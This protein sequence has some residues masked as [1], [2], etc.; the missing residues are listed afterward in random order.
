MIPEGLL[1]PVSWRNRRCTAAKAEIMNGR[2]KWKAK[3]RVRVALSTEK[4]PQIHSTKLVP[5]YGIADKRL[6]ITVAPQKD[7]WPHGN[8]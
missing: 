4:P 2:M 6:V 3:N 1:D 8:T 7:I 5:M